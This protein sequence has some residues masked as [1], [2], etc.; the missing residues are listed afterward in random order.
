MQPNAPN[1]GK[2]SW[3][4]LEIIGIIQSY[5]VVFSVEPNA[6]KSAQQ[7]QRQLITGH[8]Q[9]YQNHVNMLKI[10][11]QNLGIQNLVV[12]KIEFKQRTSLEGS[13]GVFSKLSVRRKVNTH[14]GWSSNGID[15]GRKSSYLSQMSCSCLNCGKAGSII[16]SISSLNM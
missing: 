4:V 2:V 1:A 7:R 15:D 6:T 14:P 12:Y 13:L 9:K 16:K 10:I 8:D 3:C 11:L 5:P